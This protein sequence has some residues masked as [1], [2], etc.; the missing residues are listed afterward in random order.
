MEKTNE[1]E[2]CCGNCKHLFGS[3]FLSIG[4][5]CK[6]PENQKEEMLP[7]ILNLKKR[8]LRKLKG[9]FCF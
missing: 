9:L 6:H 1:K 5:R 2:K 7:I 4:F 8:P 3:N